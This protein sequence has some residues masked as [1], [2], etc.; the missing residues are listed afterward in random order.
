MFTQGQLKTLGTGW[1]T[2][3]GT[4]KKQLYQDDKADK[5]NKLPELDYSS[6]KN[7]DKAA[8]TKMSGSGHPTDSPIKVKKGQIWRSVGRHFCYLVCHFES[9]LVYAKTFF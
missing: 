4:P 3:L 9:S 1:G 5:G 6:R 7:P 8:F 2:Y